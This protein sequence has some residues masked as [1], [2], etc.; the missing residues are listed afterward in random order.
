MKA[1]HWMW[2]CVFGGVLRVLNLM[3]CQVETIS[4]RRKVLVN[5]LLCG[6]R[7]SNSQRQNEWKGVKKWWAIQI[8][9]PRLVSGH[10]PL[11][12]GTAASLSC[13]RPAFLCITLRLSRSFSLWCVKFNEHS[14]RDLRKQTW[15]RSTRQYERRCRKCKWQLSEKSRYWSAELHFMCTKQTRKGNVFRSCILH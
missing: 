1:I 4:I 3:W 11:R 9:Q 13:L 14:K 15:M 8:I 10:E 6:M 2:V 5:L 7:S 12:R